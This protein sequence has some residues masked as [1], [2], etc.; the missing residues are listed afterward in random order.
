[1]LELKIKLIE[2]ISKEIEYKIQDAEDAFQLAKES[3]D[4]DTKSSAGDKYETGREM[5]QKEMDKYYA[6]IQQY[7]NQILQLKQNNTLLIKTSQSTFLVCIGLGKIELNN[8]YYF[9]IS[10]ESPVGQ[11]IKGKK[12]GDFYVINGKSFVIQS[13]C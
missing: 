3:R 11:Q 9:A 4:N 8:D 1:M 10:W 6:L 13:I 5:M 12:V 7:K 2:K